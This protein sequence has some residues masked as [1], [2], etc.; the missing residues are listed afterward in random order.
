M[1]VCEKRSVMA[2]AKGRCTPANVFVGKCVLRQVCDKIGTCRVTSESARSQ[3]VLQW[4][5]TICRGSL[6][7]QPFRKCQESCGIGAIVIFDDLAQ[8]STQLV[9]T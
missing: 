4:T 5:K 8:A 6:A 1:W 9:T 2:D 3:N 7:P